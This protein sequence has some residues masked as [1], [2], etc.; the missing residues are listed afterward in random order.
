MNIT[1]V[2]HDQEIHQLPHEQVN[3]PSREL[4]LLEWEFHHGGKMWGTFSPGAIPYFT[5]VE[6]TGFNK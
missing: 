5:K 2:Q 4:S 3:L 1:C 6:S